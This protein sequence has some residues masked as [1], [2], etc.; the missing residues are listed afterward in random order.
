MG[1]KMATM[2][3]IRRDKTKRSIVE[4]CVEVVRISWEEVNK[5]DLVFIE[6]DIINGVPT[7]VYGKHKVVDP[8]Q[9]ILCN[10][11]GIKFFER[12]ECLFK[13]IDSLKENV[14]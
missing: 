13:E 9:R 14:V 4:S 11:S 8:V 2:K 5:D 12:S 6:G 1:D 3:W 10:G 7:A